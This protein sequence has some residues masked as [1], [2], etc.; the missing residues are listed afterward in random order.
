MAAFNCSFRLILSLVEE[1][2]KSIQDV[3]MILY[4]IESCWH[5]YLIQEIVCA[6]S[7]TR[8]MDV[9]LILL[10]QNNFFVHS[11]TLTFPLRRRPLQDS[12]IPL[13]SNLGSLL[14]LWAKIYVDSRTSANLKKRPKGRNVKGRIATLAHQT[15]FIAA[16][17]AQ[18]QK[19]K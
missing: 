14:R 11:M 6:S 19:L 4:S 2:T 3:L 18:I 16:R 5:K 13:K 1:G 12:M 7:A 10:S 15:K 8:G 9:S 17:D